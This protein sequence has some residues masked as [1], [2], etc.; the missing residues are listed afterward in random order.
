MIVIVII[1]ILI[2]LVFLMQVLNEFWSAIKQ[3]RIGRLIFHFFI[4][5][6]VFWTIWEECNLVADIIKPITK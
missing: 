1:S 4:L 6:L 5:T 2:S 3:A